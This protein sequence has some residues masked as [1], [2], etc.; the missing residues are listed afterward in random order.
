LINTI[1]SAYLAGDFEEAK[2]LLKQSFKRYDS[3]SDNEK[4]FIVS[5]HLNINE[6]DKALI[7]LKE[8][9]N[10]DKLI[11]ESEES[12]KRQTFLAQIK[13]WTLSIDIGIRILKNVLRVVEKRI[14][15]FDTANLRS[16]YIVAS[17]NLR[18]VGDLQAVLDLDKHYPYP[19][20]LELRDYFFK[21]EIFRAKNYLSK[22]SDEINFADF[23]SFFINAPEN[24]LLQ[25]LI[26]MHELETKVHFNL[27][28]SEDCHSLERKLNQCTIVPTHLATYYYLIGHTKL[29]MKENDEA[30]YFF[31]K[32]LSHTNF[33]LGKLSI[34]FWI[35]KLNPDYGNTEDQIFLRCAPI[36]STVGHLSGNCFPLSTSSLCIAMKLQ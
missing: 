31:I 9:I 1:R 21:L 23:Y 32:A 25:L 19:P 7:L 5:M 28:T 27:L 35:N 12:L 22:S 18:V 17:S 36:G 33:T 16:I 14:K 4:S 30:L 10:V 24:E 6:S 2:R 15:N 3:F 13:I 34:I 8:E 20:V 29:A 11:D 26:T